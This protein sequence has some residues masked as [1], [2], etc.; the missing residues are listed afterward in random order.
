MLNRPVTSRPVTSRPVVGDLDA[1]AVEAQVLLVVVVDHTQTPHLVGGVGQFGRVHVH[2]IVD[3]VAEQGG[4]A[5]D[6]DGRILGF[7]D[8][9][10]RVQVGD[11]QGLLVDLQ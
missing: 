3:R 5:V 11:L 9:L 2:A 7:A 1:A 6:V 4:L 8:G 10:A